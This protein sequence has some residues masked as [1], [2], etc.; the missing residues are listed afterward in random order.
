MKECLLLASSP[1]FPMFKHR[2]KST[3]D[4]AAKSLHFIKNGLNA[5]STELLQILYPPLCLH[6]EETLETKQRLLCFTCLELLSP[7]DPEH[8]C[9]T[10]FAECKEKNR[11]H[12]CASRTTVIH[13]Q[14][15]ACEAIGPAKTLQTR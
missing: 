1:L 6:C 4:L 8:R 13:R 12:R 10:C 2:N 9:K 11:C 15:A 14:A 5:L 7:I 3:R